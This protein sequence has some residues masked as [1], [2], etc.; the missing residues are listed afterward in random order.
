LEVLFRLEHGNYFKIMLEVGSKTASI[1][2]NSL[3]EASNKGLG[4]SNPNSITTAENDQKYKKQQLSS[5]TATGGVKA[6]ET[7]EA[8][9]VS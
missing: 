9:I 6:E 8:N 7:A 4:A 2:A 5:V 3:Q 1:R